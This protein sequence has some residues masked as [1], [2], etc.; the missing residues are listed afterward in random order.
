M[1]KYGI[2]AVLVAAVAAAGVWGWSAL[3][4]R[5]DS[6]ASSLPADV[7]MVGRVDLK[8][9]VLDYGLDFADLKDLLFSANKDEKTGIKFQTA[10]YV[11]ASQGYFGGIVALE[12]DNDF[13]AFLKKQGCEVEEQRGLRWAVIENNVLLG[14]DDDRAMLMGPA[15]GSE[16]DALRNTVATCLKQSDSESGK[17]SRIYKLLEQRKEPVAISSN[18]SALPKKLLSEYLSYLPGDL[19]L[20]DLDVMAGFTAQ[21]ERLGLSFAFSS[22]NES[23][24]RQMDKVDKIF[25]QIE[26][27]LVRTTPPSPLFHM[28]MN[29]DGED[30]LERLREDKTLRTGLLALNMIFDLDMVVKSIDGDVALTCPEYSEE[31][32][33]LLFQAE[34]EDDKFMKKVND[35]NDAPT[36]AMGVNFYSQDSHN[37]MCTVAGMPVYFGTHD[38]R[39]SI[40]NTEALVKADAYADVKA[41]MADEMK[42]N[43]LFAVLNVD[44]LRPVVGQ[45]APES[46]QFLDLFDRLTL[47]VPDVRE[48]RFELVTREGVDLLQVLK[49]KVEE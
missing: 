29:V 6:M 46:Q 12:D 22:E 1:K 24:N 3:T 25:G 19:S 34:V 33:S 37:A 32:P 23:L 18:L 2:I 45:Y 30:L 44:K 48:M 36:K 14:F 9:L 42:G 49:E 8:T 4:G 17:Q 20:D 15:V 43:R 39:L 21:K 47:S 10:A 35:W 41:K 11:F 5:D 27:S 28:V 16:Q 13:E 38:D 26:S 31:L 7:T 40:S